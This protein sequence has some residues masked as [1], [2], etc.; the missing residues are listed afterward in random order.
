M[1]ELTRVLIILSLGLLSFAGSA[2]AVTVTS[3]PST[4]VSLGGANQNWS[5]TNRAQLQDNS[6]AT[7]TV[8]TG[9]LT[10]PLQCTGY[11]FAIPAAAVINGITV[12]VW[13]LAS[14]NACCTDVQM[15]LVKAGTIQPTDRSTGTL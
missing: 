10:D 6:Y 1:S 7:A 15:Q 2:G 8:N 13:R 11:G 5:N 9:Q 14:N 3:G 4:C 12:T